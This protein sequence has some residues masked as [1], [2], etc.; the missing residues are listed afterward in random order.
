MKRMNIRWQLAFYD[1]FILAAVDALMLVFSGPSIS[2]QRVAT[3][4]AIALVCIF[5]ARLLGNVYGQIWR[6]GGIQCY[7]RLIVTDTVAFVLTL[8]V[9]RSLLTVHISF[10]R[11]MAIACMNLLGALTM[12]MFY[13]YAFKC[14]NDST[15][16]GRVLLTVL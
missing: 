8:L 16:L 14:G 13:R 15:V 9:E 11:M 1:L 7:I 2:A 3:E 5:A 10:A 4:F 6:Y 12:R